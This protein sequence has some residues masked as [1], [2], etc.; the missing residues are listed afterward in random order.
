MRRPEELRCTE[1]EDPRVLLEIFD[2]SAGIVAAATQHLGLTSTEQGAEALG[3]LIVLESEWPISELLGNTVT[4]RG[5]ITD[6][7]GNTATDELN[8]VPV[9]EPGADYCNSDQ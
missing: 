8:V 5:E 9:C 4:L 1:L 6:A 3:I 7:C 2:Q